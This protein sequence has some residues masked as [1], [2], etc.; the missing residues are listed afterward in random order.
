MKLF[1]KINFLKKFKNKTFFN[2]INKNCIMKNIFNWYFYQVLSTHFKTLLCQIDPII[3]IINKKIENERKTLFHFLSVFSYSVLIVIYGNIGLHYQATGNLLTSF[4]DFSLS[5]YVYTHQISPR[6]IWPQIDL[7]L[8]FIDVLETLA[9]FLALAFTQK[10]KTKFTFFLLQKNQN[11]KQVIKLFINGQRLSKTETKKLLT[12]RK[13]LKTIFAFIV[14]GYFLFGISF[15]WVNLWLN[16]AYTQNAISTLFFFRAAREGAKRRLIFC[17]ELVGYMMC[18]AAHFAER[19]LSS[20]PC[21][22]LEMLPF[23][24][25]LFFRPLHSFAVIMFSVFSI[26]LKFCILVQKVKTI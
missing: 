9:I 21:Q 15:F 23:S 7:A 4:T 12:V 13:K 25:V 26:E 24:L 16:S 14:I 18:S 17:A 11:D 3:F 1:K 6:A 2:L 10:I 20:A 19:N 5:L 8:G 22:L